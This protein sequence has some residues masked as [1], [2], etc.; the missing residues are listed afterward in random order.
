MPTYDYE[1]T[2][3]GH[4]FEKFQ[5]ITAKPLKTCPECGEAVKRLMGTGGGI[6]LKGSGFYHTDYKKTASS[7]SNGKTCGKNDNS[8]PP[9]A[10][11]GKCC[12]N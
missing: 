1:C 4:T 9:C 11:T 6:I 2:K 12:N 10:N 5:N 3:C 7:G 8:P